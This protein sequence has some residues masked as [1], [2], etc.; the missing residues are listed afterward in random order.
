ML[1]K[2]VLI[3]LSFL[4]PL[5]LAE[6]GLRLIEHTSFGKDKFNLLTAATYENFYFFSGIGPARN[7]Y[8]RG[9]HDPLLGWRNT[10]R[11]VINKPGNKDSLNS[12]GW[13]GPEYTKQKNKRQRVILAGASFSYGFMVDD[14]ETISARLQ[15]ELGDDTEVLSMAVPAYGIDQIAL[16][17][18]Q[19]APQYNPDIIIFAFSTADFPNSCPSFNFN[20]RKPHFE[21]VPDGIELHG[22]PVATPGEVLAEHNRIGSRIWD[23]VV[24]TIAHSRIVRIVG[25][26]AL[27]RRHRD[28]L[29]KLNPAIF[30]YAGARIKPGTRMIFA[31]LDGQLQPPVENQLRQLPGEYASLPPM[32][33]QISASTGIPPDRFKDSH[34]RPNLIRLYALALAQV[35]REPV[36]K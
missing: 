10:G 29:E 4:I 36:S 34:P 16:V 28:C 19:I 32:I 17:A 7:S 25:Q 27:Q 6:A 18:T 31:L 1:K 35:L 14:S 2:I 9:P 11:P 20:L 5:A 22:V 23:G 3:S 24:T 21:L 30:K 12:D 26:I 13:R 15:K 33:R 8:A